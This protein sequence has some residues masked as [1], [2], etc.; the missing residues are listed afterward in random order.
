MS[1]R[2]RTAAL[3]AG[4]ALVLAALGLA[5]GPAS[6][7]QPTVHLTSSCA[8]VGAS[9][10]TV[11]G[12]VTNDVTFGD[13]VVKH[14]SR[15]VV[16]DP[17]GST[18]ADGTATPPFTFT[19][20]LAQASAS[21]AA[22]LHWTKDGFEATDTGTVQ[23]P[24]GCTP[25]PQPPT[26]G[27]G[28]APDCGHVL[29]T[30]PTYG[31]QVVLHNGDQ[32]LGPYPTPH[33]FLIPAHPTALVV[34][35]TFTA[36]R[37][38]PHEV[39]VTVPACPA[40]PTLTPSATCTA[41]SVAYANAPAGS[42]VDLSFE[43]GGVQ[44]QPASGTG[45]AVFE[46]IGAHPGLVLHGAVSLSGPGGEVLVRP[47]DVVV[48]ACPTTPPNPGPSSGPTT[49]PSPVVTTPPARHRPVP[50]T[51]AA[52]PVRPAPTTPP[53]RAVPVTNT[54]QETVPGSLP[55]TGSPVALVVAVGLI[56]LAAG[57]VLVAAGRRR[58]TPSVSE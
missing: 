8:D 24:Y 7:H 12:T 50:V 6:A 21:L 28:S 13:A 16:P 27:Y 35:L 42:H 44:S 20:P 23:K 30:S 47:V 1:V 46:G 41:V 49:P 51:S 9:S 22:T 14:L 38:R 48:P 36:P 5:A 40:P 17:T 3:G 25:P 11:H 10:W 54:S 26:G 33:T 56:A 2:S 32:E 29:A 55:N 31:A 15:A 58:R 18:L 37:H 19:V 45:T 4:T 39:S 57:G 43:G 53:A 34:Q 52:A